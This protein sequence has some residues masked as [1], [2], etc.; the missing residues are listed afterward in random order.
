MSII[1]ET[2]KLN[3][4]YT[5][6]KVGFGTWQI[7]NGDA[8]YNA[9]ATALKL[10]YRHIDSARGYQNEQSVGQAI[11]DSGIPREEIYLT[12]KLPAEI[13]TYQ[14][15]LDSFEVSMS[16]FGDEINYVDLY[17]IHAPWPWSRHGESD[18]KGNLEVWRAMSELQAAGRIRS[19][20]VSNFSVNDLKN[21]LENSDT[22]PAVNQI[23]WFVGN[24]Q[25]EVTAFCRENDIL[26]EAY[27]PLATGRI[28]E[29]PEIL[30]IA[31]KYDRTLPQICLRY[32]LQKDILP[33]PKSTHAEY[34]EQNADLDF[35]INDE[36][37]AFLDKLDYT[38]I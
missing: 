14:E 18:D 9:T 26:V 7:P 37:M 12:T 15:A 28:L 25:D 36:D 22:K 21:I 11:V 2:F 23:R 38:N 13:K 3:D 17:L 27:S 31:K 29:D 8:A 34:I 35:E 4:G 30:S 1:R 24:T 5:I 20:G 6:P 32:C 19:I 16:E 33:L 10:G